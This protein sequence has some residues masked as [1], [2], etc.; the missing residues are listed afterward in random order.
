MGREEVKMTAIDGIEDPAEQVMI[1]GTL[2]LSQSIFL[3]V[4]TFLLTLSTCYLTI[5]FMSEVFEMSCKF[6]KSVDCLNICSY[7]CFV[8]VCFSC[9]CCFF[10]FGCGPRH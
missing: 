2:S 5:F 10:A 4:S 9:C 8:F 6:R 1:L 7:Y 3:S